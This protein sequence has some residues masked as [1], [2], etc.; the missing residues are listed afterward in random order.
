LPNKASL[1]SEINLITQALTVAN[2]HDFAAL[3]ESH[4]AIMAQ[5]LKLDPVKTR[6]FPDFK[7][8]I[9]SLGARAA[10]LY[11]WLPHTTQ[12]RISGTKASTPFALS[13]HDPKKIPTRWPGF[14]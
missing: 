13:G 8:S 3:L 14:L 6:L 11:W 2:A 12:Q 5:I 1:L 7:G 9:K 10:I 4:E